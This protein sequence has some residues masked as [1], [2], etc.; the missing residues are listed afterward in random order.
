MANVLKKHGIS[1]E[2]TQG[3]QPDGWGPDPYH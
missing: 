1:F 3:V 2:L